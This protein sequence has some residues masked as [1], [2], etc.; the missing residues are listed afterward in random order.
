MRD[1]KGEFLLHE[2]KVLSAVS[3]LLQE[4]HLQHGQMPERL[5]QY[6][7]LQ[8]RSRLLQVVRKQ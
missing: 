4:Q 8:A 2:R 5:L 1:Y 7:G 3:D 6:I